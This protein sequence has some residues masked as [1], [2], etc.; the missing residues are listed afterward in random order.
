MLLIFHSFFLCRSFILQKLVRFTLFI[1]CSFLGRERFIFVLSELLFSF[2][3]FFE[4][5]H[6]SAECRCACLSLSLN[7]PSEKKKPQI[8]NIVGNIGAFECRVVRGHKTKK[9]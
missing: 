6:F 7:Y 1:H 5:N 2:F 4:K 3:S 8:Q 9:G